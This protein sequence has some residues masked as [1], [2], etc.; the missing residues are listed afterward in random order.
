MYWWRDNWVP[1]SRPCAVTTG[2]NL[3]RRNGTTTSANLASSTFE[4]LLRLMIKMAGLSESILPFSIW[5]SPTSLTP[6]SHSY[7]RQ[8]ERPTLSMHAT[9]CP[10]AR[11][12]PSQMTNGLAKQSDMIIFTLLALQPT[13]ATT[14]MSPCSL[15]A[16]GGAPNWLPGVSG[17]RAMC[18]TQEPC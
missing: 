8:R 9:A 10:V 17:A 5:S 12:W 11:N 2:G 6:V 3:H 13:F 4:S 1:K 18:R 15:P 16:I 7:S 14:V